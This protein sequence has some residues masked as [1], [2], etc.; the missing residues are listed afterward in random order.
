MQAER[1]REVREVK[2]MVPRD[3]MSKKARKAMDQEKRNLWTMNPVT[4]VQE[5]K[6]VYSRKR[7]KL[8]EFE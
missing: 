5:S 8:A 6:K 7:D 2:G 3:R 1:M 4:R